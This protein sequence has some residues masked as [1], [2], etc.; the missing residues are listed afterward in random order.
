M[1]HDYD[2]ML[3][4]RIES[5]KQLEAKFQ[6][7]ARKIQANKEFTNAEVKRVKDTLKAFQSKFEYK[8]KLLREEFEE[9]IRQ[10][11]EYNK[12]A[13]READERMDGIEESIQKE[14]QDRISE[15]DE[16]IYVVKNDLGDLQT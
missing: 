15:T 1:D 11:R 12:Q 9:K 7:I 10:M 5:K 13:F 14:I 2:V 6:D 3:M 8:L 4:E 16:K